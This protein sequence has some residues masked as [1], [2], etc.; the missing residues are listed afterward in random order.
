MARGR[1]ETTDYI[2]ESDRLL[3]LEEQTVWVL[4]PLGGFDGGNIASRYGGSERVKSKGF[5]EVSPGKY[6][7]ADKDTWI[8]TIVTVKNYA[9]NLKRYPQYCESPP[10]DKNG[11][12]PEIDG[13]EM[14]LAVGND[15]TLAEFNEL[16]QAALDAGV[17]SPVA[18]KK[19]R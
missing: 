7:L 13:R 12:I 14:I 6:R 17:P 18:K 2:L 15:I 5:R 16:F 3:P 11:Y 9:F 4:K 8:D 19:S 10:A 1:S